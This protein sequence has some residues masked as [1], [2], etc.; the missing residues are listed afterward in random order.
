MPVGLLVFVDRTA[1]KSDTFI[2]AVVTVYPIKTD[3]EEKLRR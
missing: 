2:D 1:S 3:H